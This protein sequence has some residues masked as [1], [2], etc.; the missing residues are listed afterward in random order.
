MPLAVVGVAAYWFGHINVANAISGTP[1]W[2]QDLAFFHQWVHSAATGGPWASPLILEPQGFFEQV[3]THLVLPLVVALYRV[4]PAQETLLWLHSLGAALALWPTFRLSEQLAGGRHAM[5]VCAAVALFGPLQGV[6]VADFRPVVLF[7]PGIL[8]LWAS[9]HR[10]ALLATLGWALLALIGRQEASYLIALSGCALWVAPWGNCTKRISVS[11]VILGTLSWASFALLKP[12]MFF[13]INLLAE[14]S[15]PT[16]A[17][18]WERRAH[19][20]GAIMLSGWWIGLSRPAPLLALS[21]ILYSMLAS[22]REWHAL[23][24]PGAHHHVFWM[25]FVLAAGISASVHLKRGLGLALL[26]LGGA[27]SFPHAART[28]AN[29]A[30]YSLAELVPPT[31]RVAADYTTIHKLAGRET[32]WNVDQLYMPDRPHHWQGRW[33]LTVADVDWILAPSDHTVSDH[34]SEWT[35]VSS[36]DGHTLWKR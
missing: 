27:F 9:A 20:A 25:P 29:T 22:S 17:E 6:A 21:P 32:L 34:L 26:L 12:Q 3:H 28:N 4:F 8:G 14:S 33:P 16:S 30:V 11:L 23:T 24:G 2:G 7:L 31:G 36:V 18:L 1:Q 35:R 15:W 19:F 10:G 5:G 13:H